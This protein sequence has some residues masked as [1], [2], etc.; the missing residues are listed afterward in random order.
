[1]EQYWIAIGVSW[2]GSF[3]GVL[4]V[5]LIS[6]GKINQIIRQHGEQLQEVKEQVN[7]IAGHTKES[8]ITRG[9]CEVKRGECNTSI[10]SK[11]DLVNKKL[12]SMD[13]QREDSRKE[14]KEDFK[15]IYDKIDSLSKTGRGG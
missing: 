5:A 1:M 3:I 8:A 7:V 10:C 9:E 13:K 6:W 11:I 15:R 14:T 4:T 2:A 12:L